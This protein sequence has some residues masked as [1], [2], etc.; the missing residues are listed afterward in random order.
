[1]KWL[2]PLGLLGLMGL[3]VLII[4][5]IIKPNYQQKI[6][7]ST[8]LWRLS[9]QYRKKRLPVSR[10]WNILLFL[11][12]MLTIVA[13][14][15]SMAQPLFLMEKTST[16][17]EY[18]IILDAS[19][20]MHAAPVG[21]EQTRFDRA[22]GQIHAFVDEMAETGS[23]MSV[24]VADHQPYYVIQR[25]SLENLDVIHQQLDALQNAKN[26]RCTYGFADMAAAM[27]LADEILEEN[28]AA[29]VILY[30]GTTYTSPGS[31]QVVNVADSNEWNAAILNAE[32]VLSENYYEFQI[33]LGSFGKDT[34]IQFSA[35][36]YGVNEAKM[37][38]NLTHMV[39]C[40]Q[41]T[42]TV[43]VTVGN[44]PQK[45]QTQSNYIFAEIYIYDYAFFR[46]DAKDSLDEDNALYLYGGRKPELNIQY[47]SSVPNQ[48]FSGA[49][50][51]L[52]SIMDDTWD[53]HVK[54]LKAE[55]EPQLTGF[56]VYIFEHTMPAQLPTDGL[57]ILVNP[58]KAPT[59]GG[60]TL[61]EA[62]KYEK[63]MYLRSGEG[64][65][66]LNNL[67]PSEISVTQ[68]CRIT[69]YGEQYVPILYCED[70]P[71]VLASNDPDHQVMI[72]AFSLH[73]SNLP[74]LMDFPVLMYNI[75]DHYIPST[76]NKTLFEVNETVTLHARAD[77]LEL[78]GPGVEAT[79]VQ[80]PQELTVR[81]PGVYS[82]MQEPVADTL[83]VENFFVKIPAEESDIWRVEAE[84]PNPQ[85]FA[86]SETVDTDM[87]Y[88]LAMILIALLFVEWWLQAREY[89]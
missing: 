64:S 68:L 81:V 74:V 61:G 58:D 56:D 51:A 22:I 29:K 26:N 80:L 13:I 4:I 45:A 7:S 73:R 17:D 1:M 11:C 20:D 66:I 38:L 28:D 55:E 78:V 71:V 77:S 89:F 31:V 69:N 54:T 34:Q 14:S 47:A 53:I 15:L 23:A 27:L 63:E 24:I 79:L 36:F 10:L 37:T 52:R 8:H 18:V 35:D 19:A 3:I 85:S 84:L 67:K 49:L 12:Q 44:D 40:T 9:L 21:S 41:D 87:V 39:T 50:M 60:F 82:L 76:V 59:D 43:I 70:W 57:V 86:E 46:I 65:P 42:G 62:Q 75:L 88:Y 72:M 25:E 33:E 30:T 2:T 32:A 83:I 48:F 5:Y 16:E 6:L